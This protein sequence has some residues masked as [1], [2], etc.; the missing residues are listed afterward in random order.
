MK[1]YHP[2]DRPW[3]IV[4]SPPAWATELPDADDLEHEPLLGTLALLQASSNV[5][6][7]ALHSRHGTAGEPSD[8]LFKSPLCSAALIARLVVHRCRELS[9]LLAAYRITLR[10]DAD[11]SDDF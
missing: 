11:D 5:A 6:V 8:E 10:H 4:R 9:D 1:I 2:A 7:A 3:E